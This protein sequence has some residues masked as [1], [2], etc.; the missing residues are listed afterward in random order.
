MPKSN[1]M[2]RFALFILCCAAFVS[3]AK[4]K[5]EERPNATR[6]AAADWTRLVMG[7]A[8]LTTVAAVAYGAVWI[9]KQERARAKRFTSFMQEARSEFG[10]AQIPSAVVE[11]HLKLRD[12]LFQRYGP[13]GTTLD[14]MDRSIELNG[15]YHESWQRRLPP[16]AIQEFKTVL[17]RRALATL[18]AYEASKHDFEAKAVLYGKRLIAD[19][20]W[21]EVRQEYE[22]ICE[23]LQFIIFDANC[24]E[25][26]WG[27]RQ[28]G[29]MHTATV[30]MHHERMKQQ[31]EEAKRRAAKQEEKEKARQLKL[32]EHAEKEAKEKLERQKRAAEDVLRELLSSEDQS[33]GG[34]SG[35]GGRMK[36]TPAK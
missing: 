18:P 6:G 27:T 9:T 31:E 11:T 4:P 17:L 2:T 8:L 13:Q 12:A 33:S 16:E 25:H 23:Q 1:K 36:K 14:C 3:A 28:N 20:H 22:D 24:L 35:A 19:T 26:E 34:G 32:K 30:L 7:A 21:N 29:L 5:V 15:N 10:R